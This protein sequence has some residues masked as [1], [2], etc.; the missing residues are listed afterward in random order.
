[1]GE[2]AKPSALPHQDLVIACVRRHCCLAAA[3]RRYNPSRF[4]IAQRRPLAFSK[5]PATT[6]ERGAVADL[7][8]RFDKD[9]LTLSTTMDAFFREHDFNPDAERDYAILCEPELIEEEFRLESVMGTPCFV[10]PTESITAARLAKERFDGRANDVAGAA[11]ALAAAFRPQHIIGAVAPSGL[12]LDPS[13]AASLKQSRDQYKEA[14]TALQLHPYEAVF[15][16]GFQNLTDAQCALMGARSVFDGPVFLSLQLTEEGL[17]PH[18]DARL[19]KAA[20]MLDEYGAT[21][22]GMR[23]GGSPETLTR[24]VAEMRQGTDRPLLVEIEVRPASK[25]LL[26][27]PVDNPY[28]HPETLMPAAL[29]LR[30]AGV[31]FLR[32]AGDAMP[33]CTGVLLSAIEGTDVV[34]DKEHA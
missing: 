33:A 20:A 28:W 25:R 29:A 8:L 16:C 21:V 10:A 27:A 6:I 34:C 14:V 11:F 17:L 19:Q 12:P 3:C 23:C 5:L 9:M 15:F 18:D 30:E 24:A 4:Q 26:N 32:A 22:V 7:A 1:M 13:S 31:Q 2:Q